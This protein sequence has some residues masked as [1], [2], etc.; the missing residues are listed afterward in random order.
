MISRKSKGKKLCF[1]KSNELLP[2]AA[3]EERKKPVPG[4]AEAAQRAFK[5]RV[6]ITEK[7]RSEVSH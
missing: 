4:T 3:Y 6:R 1:Q 7:R 5:G 2:E